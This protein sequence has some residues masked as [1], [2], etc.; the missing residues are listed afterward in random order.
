M[1][2]PLSRRKFVMLMGT[3]SAGLLAAACSSAA[4]ASPTAAPAAPAKPAA[5][6]TTQAAPAQGS[7]APAAAKTDDF[8]TQWD[9]LVDAASKEGKLV[10]QNP[11]GAGYRPALDEFQKM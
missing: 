8:K 3:A 1:G 11:A 10:V 7:G 2:Q 6:P 9:A 4:P 5:Q